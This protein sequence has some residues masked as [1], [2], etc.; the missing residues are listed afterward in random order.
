VK[1]GVKVGAGDIEVS[2]AFQYTPIVMVLS[3][4]FI[5]APAK[6]L[7]SQFIPVALNDGVN[8]GAKQIHAFVQVG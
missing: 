7:G 5:R 1:H 6:R 4:H 2:G 3:L 8:Q